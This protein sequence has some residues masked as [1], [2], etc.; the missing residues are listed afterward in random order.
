MSLYDQQYA[1][2]AQLWVELLKVLW[3]FI[4]SV[5]ESVA[6]C[7][8]SAVMSF[9]PFSPLISWFFGSR[10]GCSA[11][12]KSV[13]S[14]PNRVPEVVVGQSALPAMAFGVGSAWLGD[15]EHQEKLKRTVQMAL[16]AGFRHLDLAEAY[17]N[18]H[19]VGEAVQEWLQKTGCKREEPTETNDT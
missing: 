12:A 11:K 3:N 2:V 8:V 5:Q 15:A 18:S 16:D 6:G 9:F 13:A 17:D 4:L 14:E 19:V 10:T 1:S 7:E